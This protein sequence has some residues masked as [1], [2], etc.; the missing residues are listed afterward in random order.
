M[1]LPALVAAPFI[2]ALGP[3][4]KKILIWLLVAKGAAIIMR[5][6]LVLGIALFTN[7]W[8]VQPLLDQIQGRA[9]GIPPELRVWLSAF[10]ID[11]VISIVATA[12]LLLGTKRVFLGK[13]A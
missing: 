10:A 4:L 7:E 2:A 5:F 9:G 1:A 8:I 12:Y 3:L 13:A 11:K 6:F